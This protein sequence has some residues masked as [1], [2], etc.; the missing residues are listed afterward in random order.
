VTA[1]F[2]SLIKNWRQQQ[3]RAVVATLSLLLCGSA[4]N[5]WSAEALPIVT[6][7]SPAEI[8]EPSPDSPLLKKPRKP[9]SGSKPA[10]KTSSEKPKPTAE[11]STVA[12]PQDQHPVSQPPVAQNSEI[13]K[14]AEDLAGKRSPAQDPPPQT[15]VAQATQQ[16]SPTPSSPAV[17]KPAAQTPAPASP[18]PA[19]PE[20]ETSEK[21]ETPYGSSI[22]RN[23]DNKW[24]I[25]LSFDDYRYN[26]PIT[27][28]TGGTESGNL[29][30]V[31]LSL[32]APPWHGRSFFDFS[33]RQGLLNGDVRYPGKLSSSFQT[34]INE[35]FVGFH[36][37]TLP[38]IHAGKERGHVIGYV[39]LSW[40]GW[41]T[42]ETLLGG[43][44]WPVNGR[45]ALTT[46]LNMILANLGLGYDLVLWNPTSRTLSYRLGVRA[47][48]IGAMGGSNFNIR[49]SDQTDSL[50]V[51]G[52]ARGTVYMDL[53]LR[54][55]VTVFLE[56]GYQRSWWIF[57]EL[58]PQ[59]P[60]VNNFEGYWGGFG[61]VGLAVH[62]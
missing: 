15:S 13:P 48:A 28:G 49:G 37:E 42:T 61:R 50:A 16:Q 45:S 46:D 26:A 27:E 8:P 59:N 9:K 51:Y 21:P 43:R 47:L 20:S 62:F 41:S 6:S 3:T 32:S 60:G 24:H 53:T 39:G 29:Y 35:A 17:S 57:S 40:D 22:V 19:S 34:F 1:P 36:F 44:R 31:S 12:A 7:S 52:L 5:S 58:P 10:A 54:D 25:S 14:A 56:G 30:G 38:W 23:A 55:R 33:Y 11:P 2:A 18:P 4:L